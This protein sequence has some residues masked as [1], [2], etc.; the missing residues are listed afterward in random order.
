MEHLDTTGMFCPVPIL[1]TARRIREMAPG[2]RLEVIG[3]D[4]GIVEDMPVWCEETG[5][6]L[7]S[8]ESEG[9]IVRCVVEKAADG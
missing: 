5:N 7:C 1:L 6:R 3:D 8:L 9:K 4:P 2:E